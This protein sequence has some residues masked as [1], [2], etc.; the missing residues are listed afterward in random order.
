MKAIWRTKYGSPDVL[1]LADV[2]RPTP[3]EDE[4]LIR[5]RAASSLKPRL[6]R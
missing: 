4:V 5:V 6:I 3:N 1:Q 2:G